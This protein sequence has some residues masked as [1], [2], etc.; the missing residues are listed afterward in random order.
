[1]VVELPEQ[2]GLRVLS[3]LVD[4]AEADVEIG[5]AVDV[6]FED[7]SADVTLPLFRPSRA[8][9]GIVNA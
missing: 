1:V 6:T 9:E 8:V 5:M 2:P 3:Q 4:C 7:V